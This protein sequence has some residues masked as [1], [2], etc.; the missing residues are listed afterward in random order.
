MIL[1]VRQV[2]HYQ[3]V[4]NG[5]ATV[6]AFARAWRFLLPVT[7]LVLS[8]Q[9]FSQD[10]IAEPAKEGEV[11]AQLA[12]GIGSVNSVVSSPWVKEWVTS[13]SSLP[14]IQPHI[15][16]FKGKELMIDEAIYYSSRYGSPL[17]YAR[18]L[19]LAVG[20]GFKADRGSRIFD[21]GYGSIGHLNMLALLGHECVGVDIAP[22][23]KIMYAGSNGPVGKGS[24]KVLDGLF[25]KDLD[26]VVNVGVDYDLV[27]SKNVLK[28]G[29][30]HP[31]RDVPDPRMV[32]DLGVDD[33]SFLARIAAMLKPNGL[34]VI[35]NFCPAKASAD[36][37]YIPWAEGES[38]FT[39]GAF[40]LAG[41]EI[42]H[43]DVVDDLDARRLGHAL[44]WDA[45]GGMKLET[46][47][48]AWYTIV[49]RK[50]NAASP[51]S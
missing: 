7:W 18:A 48:F 31:S 40:Q 37:P 15:V 41:F 22:L 25:P 30:I 33:A 11:V 39:R 28:Q 35:Y 10:K 3:F 46:D 13:V 49:R 32:I 24:V 16:Q 5:L 29:Y 38:P 1:R 51:K 34:F 17:A 2:E 9:G 19:D 42:L 50:P 12:K 45:D 14:P 26:L 43:F 8:S 36:K 20:A 47:L 6:V 4:S 23:L 44:G 27:I 21:F